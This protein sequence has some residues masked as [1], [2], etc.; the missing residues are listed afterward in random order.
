MLARAPA[1]TLA[2][3]QN[4]TPR[5]TRSNF[6]V[7]KIFEYVLPGVCTPIFERVLKLLFMCTSGL[8]GTL[9]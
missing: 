6:E 2:R 8:L 1:T 9:L 5:S 3:I 7:I 4:R